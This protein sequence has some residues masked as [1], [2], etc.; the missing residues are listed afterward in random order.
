MKLVELAGLFVVQ[1]ERSMRA[2]GLHNPH[3]PQ[4]LMTTRPDR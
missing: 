3:G 1:A 4:P 2:L